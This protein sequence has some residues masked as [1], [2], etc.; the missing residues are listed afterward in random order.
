MSAHAPIVVARPL[1]APE[2]GLVRV[3][4][5]R[6]IGRLALE[7]R[8]HPWAAHWRL[9]RGAPLAAVVV[10][11]LFLLLFAASGCSSVPLQSVRSSVISPHPAQGLRCESV[12]ISQEVQ[13]PPEGEL[14]DLRVTIDDIPPALGKLRILVRRPRFAAALELATD[15][16]PEF[17]KVLDLQPGA[18][19]RSLTVVLAR[20]RR[21]GDGWPRRD[22][23]ACRVDV[24]L[25]GL[26][27]GPEALDGFFARAL[28]DASAIDAAFAAQSQEPATRPGA[29]LRDFSVSLSAEARRCGVAL[30]PV[31]R[32][33]QSALGQLDAA[34]AFL[35]GRDASIPDAPAVFRS[36]EAATAAMEGPIATSARRAGWPSSLRPGNAGR[37]RASALHLDAAAQLAAL[38][39]SDKPTAARWVAVA[40]ATDA[41]SLQQRLSALPAIRDL[42]DAQA[43]LDELTGL[44][45]D[46]S[47]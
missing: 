21:A 39:P 8:L 22:C 17:D 15:E 37:L 33:V 11:L 45:R 47:L 13:V 19:Q 29:A 44:F 16:K 41:T 34:R 35:Y 10:A 4:W 18:G 3:G 43:R 28:Q 2:D 25:T 27:G 1:P 14:G 32:G 9:R 40:L 7:P 30:D 26:F 38:P 6:T 20:P 36:W 24:E 23:K 31:L 46:L 42:D 12:L 5:L